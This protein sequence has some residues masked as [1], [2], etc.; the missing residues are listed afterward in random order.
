MYVVYKGL[1]KDM[2]IEMEQ[3]LQFVIFYVGGNKFEVI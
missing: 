2:L 1:I 3:D